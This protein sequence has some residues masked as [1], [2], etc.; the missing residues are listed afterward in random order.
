MVEHTITEMTEVKGRC[1]HRS[2][3]Q[4]INFIATFTFLKVDVTQGHSSLIGTIEVS[5]IMSKVPTN[6]VAYNHKYKHQKVYI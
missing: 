4:A 6:T 5:L 3:N 2:I 1:V